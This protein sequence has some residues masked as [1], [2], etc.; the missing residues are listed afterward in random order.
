MQALNQGMPLLMGEHL[1]IDRDTAAQK[2]EKLENI[3][4]Y[5][6]SFFREHLEDLNQENFIPLP[7]I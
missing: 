7:M 4:L 5:C 3:C 1:G 6:D 2:A